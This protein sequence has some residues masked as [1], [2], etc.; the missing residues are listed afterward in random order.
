MLDSRVRGPWDS[1]VSV[2][3]VEPEVQ[4]ALRYRFRWPDDCV[5]VHDRAEY[6]GWFGE[7]FDFVV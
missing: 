6:V 4:E 7:D 2:M 1:G 3:M 5:V